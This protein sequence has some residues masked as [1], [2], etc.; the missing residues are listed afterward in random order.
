[1]REDVQPIIDQLK[2][3]IVKTRAELEAMERALAD[4]GGEPSPPSRLTP[5]SELVA[6]YLREKGTPLT[7]EDIVA[8]LDRRHPGRQFKK[9]IK[10][11]LEW[12]EQGRKKT[13]QHRLKRF[14]D[15]VGLPEWEG[16]F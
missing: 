2:A 11:D 6:D 13:G 5:S 1:V 8:E 7:L 9:A 15:L 14:G 4:L 12:E 3:A 16:K 10:D